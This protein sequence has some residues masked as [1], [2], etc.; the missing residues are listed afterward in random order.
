[1]PAILGGASPCQRP[2]KGEKRG[3]L[4]NGMTPRLKTRSNLSL[5][6][7]EYRITNASNFMWGYPPA[8]NPFGGTFGTVFSLGVI[9]LNRFNKI[10]TPNNKFQMTSGQGSHW[11][12]ENPTIF[13]AMCSP[14]LS[15]KCT[16]GD[17]G[18][19]YHI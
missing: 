8:S 13:S 10:A 5:G 3:H 16:L 7:P 17:F 19:T 1:M 11:L 2:P 14:P 15:N 9:P 12:I 18:A 6:F 4:F